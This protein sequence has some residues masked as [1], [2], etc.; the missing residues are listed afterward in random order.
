[1]VRIKGKSDFVITNTVKRTKRCIYCK[2]SVREENKSS[3]CCGCNYKLRRE[4]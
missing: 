3:V 4:K 2:R 1:M